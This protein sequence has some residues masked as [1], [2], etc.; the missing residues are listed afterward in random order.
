MKLAHLLKTPLSNPSTYF[1]K[2]FQFTDTLLAR[3]QNTH[4]STANNYNQSI[5]PRY[6]PNDTASTNGTAQRYHNGHSNMTNAQYEA[7]LSNYASST[8]LQSNNSDRQ[9]MN[10]ALYHQNLSINNTGVSS[11]ESD[12]NQ[13][14][15][16]NGLLNQQTESKRST[17]KT[18]DIFLISMKEMNIH[19]RIVF[20]DVYSDS[21]L[22]LAIINTKH[23]SGRMSK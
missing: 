18:Y 6:R 19:I 21:K 20:V 3:S 1:F 13:T 22:E 5:M 8:H 14:I 4:D 2:S 7:N 16:G 17:L 12:I 15:C 23:S 10:N 11:N 9:R